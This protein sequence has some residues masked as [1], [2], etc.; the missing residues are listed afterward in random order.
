M[1]QAWEFLSNPAN[2]EKITPPDMKFKILSTLEGKMYAGQ[3]IN[4]IVQPFPMVRLRWTTE[5]SQV[6]QGSYFVDE[7]R[8]GPYA[9]WHHKHFIRPVDGG[10]EMMDVVDYALPFGPLGRLVHW[11]FVRQKLQNIFDFRFQWFAETFK[12]SA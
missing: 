12:R 2:L 1:E 9:F 10:V 4:Y 7:Q 3:I 11:L 6:E 8:F 5:I